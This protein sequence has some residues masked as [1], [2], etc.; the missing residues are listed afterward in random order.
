MSWNCSL[1]VR[2][3]RRSSVDVS[4]SPEI[5]PTLP[6]LRSFADTLLNVSPSQ[7]CSS[8]LRRAFR[9]VTLKVESEHLLRMVFHWLDLLDQRTEPVNKFQRETSKIYPCSHRSAYSLVHAILR[10]G[11]LALF[12]RKH[13]LFL[14]HMCGSPGVRQL[15]CSK[16][17]SYTLHSSP[18]NNPSR[19]FQCLPGCEQHSVDE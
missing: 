6:T 11:L 5:H 1:A 4:A 14:V 12:F 8:V 16:S 17:S 9:L 18:S 7:S 3:L 19:S 2:Q 15:Q 10:E 13:L